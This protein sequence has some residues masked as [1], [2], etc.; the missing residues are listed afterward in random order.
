MQDI[1]R[2]RQNVAKMIDMGATE[3]EIDTYL[4]YKEVTAEQ[5]R[6]SKKQQPSA[7]QQGMQPYKN[8]WN[9]MQ[10]Q[11][12]AGT[13]N[14][15]KGITEPSK[16]SLLQVPLGAMQYLF[17][18][19]AGAAQ[20]PKGITEKGLTAA[21]VPEKGAEFGGRLAEEATYFVPLGW[22]AKIG[23]KATPGLQALKKVGGKA[24][25]TEK[26]VA[27]VK[28]VTKEIPKITTESL[29]TP[30]VRQEVTGA[31]AKG[32]D[33][34]LTGQ[35]DEAKRLFRNV[36]D[37]LGT[38]EIQV[39]N[40]PEILQK[41]GVAPAE[42]A[43]TYME[44]I[45]TAGRQLKQ[46]SDLSKRMKKSFANDPAA[47][48]A[49]DEI[50]DTTHFADRITDALYRMENFRRSLLVTQLATTMRNIGSQA[51]RLVLS[52]FDEA[53]QGAIVGATKGNV[54]SEIKNGLNVYTSALNRMTPSGRKRWMQIMDSKNGIVSKSRLLSTPF[55]QEAS[56][57][58]KVSRAL[59]VFNRTQETYFRKLAFESKMKQLLARNKMDW[60]TVDP[61]RIPESMY[62]EAADYALEMTFAASPKSKAGRDFVH[63]WQKLGLTTVNPFPRFAFGNALPFIFEHSPLGLT[64]MANPKMWKALANGN[65]EQFA[66]AASRATLGTLMLKSAWHIRQSEYAGEKWY[67]IKYGTDEKTGKAKYIDVRPFAPFSAYFFFAE[68]MLQHQG[69]RPKNLR[70]SD[71]AEMA[72]GLNRISGTGLV[73]IDLLRAKKPETVNDIVEDFASAYAGSFTVPARTVKDLVAH[74]SEEEAKFRDVR[75]DETWGPLGNAM[76]NIPGLSQKFPYKPSPLTTDVRKSETPLLRQTTGVSVK[77]KNLVEQEVDRLNLGY[78]SIYPRTKV[79]EADRAISALMAPMVELIVPRIIEKPLYQKSIHPQKR[80]IM[81]ALFKEIRND[82]K[83]QLLQQ[84]PQM[85]ARLKYEALSDDEKAVLKHY[86]IA[87]DIFQK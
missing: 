55:I 6:N 72:I 74:F 52:S 28:E 64:K 62:K 83:K 82:A 30:Q 12:Q 47:L 43:N 7:I 41:Y 48:K 45:S 16:K 46:L 53:L 42:F 50:E 44:T 33:D 80:L 23:S 9:T 24:V 35:Y 26:A 77:T 2:V 87:P 79:P 56:M 85:Q 31:I 49:L 1:E 32:A 25:K 86:G 3:Q 34:A 10:E 60:N 17:S 73:L 11:A 21:G 66:Q 71:Y 5:L 14:I 38:G 59:N 84:V 51:G 15:K 57:G 27:P 65:P 20:I 81:K 69:V 58:N 54:F 8:A 76:Y 70:A 39:E 67:E 37:H 4:S 63:A 36:A 61:R 40:L 78:E 22:L 19:I 75:R 13:E 18:P 29:T 68:A